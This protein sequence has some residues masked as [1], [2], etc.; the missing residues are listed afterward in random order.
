VSLP[1]SATARAEGKGQRKA[2][3]DE[4]RR[5]QQMA[6]VREHGGDDEEEVVVDDIAWEGLEDEDVLTGPSLPP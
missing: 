6:P 1:K 3:E 5:R 4:G 2:D